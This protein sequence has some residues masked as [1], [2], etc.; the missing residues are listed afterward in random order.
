MRSRREGESVA[1]VVAVALSGPGIDLGPGAVVAVGIDSGPAAG[2][3][4]AGGSV[5]A[6]VVGFGPGLDLA[7]GW[8][9]AVF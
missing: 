2:S 1:V 5:A 9:L 4:P 8:G 6:V 3:D 7:A